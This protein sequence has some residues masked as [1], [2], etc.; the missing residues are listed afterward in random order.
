MN[1]KQLF[2]QSEAIVA[3]ELGILTGIDET[4]A[5]TVAQMQSDKSRN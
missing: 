2:V 1:L 5:R 3:Q 4:M